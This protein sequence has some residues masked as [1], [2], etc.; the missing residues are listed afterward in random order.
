[1]NKSEINYKVK[2]MINR[3]SRI[4]A[5]TRE[6]INALGIQIKFFD[7]DT[8]MIHSACICSKYANMH[9]TILLEIE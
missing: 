7:Y 9:S 3:Y 2:K 8:R 1:M 5:N 6:K 4:I